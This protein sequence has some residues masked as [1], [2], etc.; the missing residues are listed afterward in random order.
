MGILGT[1]QADTVASPHLIEKA[2]DTFT[3]G[4]TTSNSKRK[5]ISLVDYL[6]GNPN[7]NNIELHI[8]KNLEKSW[9]ISEI[10]NSPKNKPKKKK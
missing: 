8:K 3:I 9:T 5:E 2:S 6:K 10:K 1:L 7:K 4:K